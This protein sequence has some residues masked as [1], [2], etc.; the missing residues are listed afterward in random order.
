MLQRRNTCKLTSYV[1]AL[2]KHKDNDTCKI[3]K[4][5]FKKKI[6][7]PW[8]RVHL[9]FEDSK[10]LYY[11][12]VLQNWEFETGG[13]YT[14]CSNYFVGSWTFMYCLWITCIFWQLLMKLH[15]HHFSYMSI[16]CVWVSFTLICFKGHIIRG[17]NTFLSQ[18]IFWEENALKL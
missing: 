3:T 4:K 9:S 6:H 2:N 18:V 12:P 8:F 5:E 13:F 16:Y 14:S 17:L 11:G 7:V 1:S 15:I 10:A